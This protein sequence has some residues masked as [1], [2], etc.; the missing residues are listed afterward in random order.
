MKMAFF[1]GHVCQNQSAALF[2]ITAAEVVVRVKANSKLIKNLKGWGEMWQECREI[3][4]K[5]YIA[6]GSIKQCS[7]FGK[8]SGSSSND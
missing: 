8:Q 2:K 5:I 4:T 3:R 7:Y 1:P 6:G